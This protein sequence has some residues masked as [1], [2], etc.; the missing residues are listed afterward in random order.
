MFLRTVFFGGEPLKARFSGRQAG[1][2][3]GPSDWVATSRIF[4]ADIQ[5]DRKTDDGALFNMTSA[6]VAPRQVQAFAYFD[7]DAG[8]P[9]RI[10]S[11]ERQ[12]WGNL[13]RV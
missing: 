9:R 3:L 2:Y 6:D 13:V 10:A 8:E 11:Q 7:R 5:P 1:Q 4:D 12:K